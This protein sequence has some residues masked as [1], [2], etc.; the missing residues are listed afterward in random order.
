MVAKLYIGI[1]PMIS[2][3]VYL[4]K[5]R[6]NCLERYLMAIHFDLNFR[7]ILVGLLSLGIF[8]SKDT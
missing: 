4:I 3:Y 6:I 1:E 2:S 5:K 7:P 8:L